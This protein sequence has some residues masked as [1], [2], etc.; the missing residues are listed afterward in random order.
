MPRAVSVTLR[1]CVLD[2]FTFEP[3]SSKNFA[4]LASGTSDTLENC[5]YRT[6]FDTQGKQAFTVTAGAGMTIDFGQSTAVYG[7][8]GITAYAAGLMYGDAFYASQGDT[9]AL[10]LTA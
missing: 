3:A 10:N 7:V 6:S 2:S 5:Y 9:V 8:S 1:S 4:R